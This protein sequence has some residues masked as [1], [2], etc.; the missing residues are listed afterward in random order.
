MA[1]F[2]LCFSMRKEFLKN[3]VSGEIIFDLISLFYVQIQEP[4]SRSTTMRAFV[5]L[6]KF[7]EFCYHKI[8]ES[9]S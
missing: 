3:K 5:F 6:A 8:F 1:V 7:A 2:E 9:R 4:T